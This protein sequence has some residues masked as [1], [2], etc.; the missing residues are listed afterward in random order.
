MCLRTLLSL[1]DKTQRRKSSR[2]FNLANVNL[3]FLASRGGGGMKDW[4]PGPRLRAE[5]HR[6]AYSSLGRV[7]WDRLELG[8]CHLFQISR[9]SC[10]LFLHL[11]RHVRRLPALLCRIF[12]K[13]TEKLEWLQGVF[14]VQKF[15][16]YDLKEPDW[17]PPNKNI[18]TSVLSTAAHTLTH[19]TRSPW[20]RQFIRFSTDAK[21]PNS[22]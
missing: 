10:R 17:P 20:L 6:E 16:F 19:L 18:P 22:K 15:T 13:G 1:I 7:A 5:R 2:N 12:W 11:L 4:R 14:Q 21:Q 3:R 9:F 8:Q